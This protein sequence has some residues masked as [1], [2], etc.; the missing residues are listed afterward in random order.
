[1]VGLGKGKVWA[2]S[3][4]AVFSLVLLTGMMLPAMNVSAQNT[5]EMDSA[6]RVA[7]NKK[8]LSEAR[9][10]WLQKTDEAEKITQYE[11]Q[12]KD[13]VSEADR[14]ALDA[15]IQE[16]LA[17]IE[18]LSAQ[19]Q[20]LEELNKKLYVMDPDLRS[21]L[22]AASNL[23]YNK[24]VNQSSTSYIGEN[25]VEDVSPLLLTRT[26]EILVNPEKLAVDKSNLPEETEVDGFPVT[27]EYGTLQ[28]TSCVSGRQS[29]CRP[30][31][32]GIS[33]ADQSLA[34]D[35]NTMGYKAV[36]NGYVGFVIAGHTSTGVLAN[37]VQ[38]H[39]D[40]TKT[41]GVVVV[42]DPNVLDAAFVK[43]NPGITV[44]DDICAGTTSCSTYYDAVSK[45]PDSQQTEGTFIIKA[46]ASGGSDL[47]EVSVNYP[48]RNNIK[49]YVC[50]WA[51]GDSGSTIF[52]ESG[53][54][55]ADI[56]GMMHLASPTTCYVYYYPQDII[57]SKIGANPAL[58]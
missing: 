48:D 43:A 21:R 25:P 29:E 52:H 46:G 30:L 31:V 15:K 22:F 49:A 47:G 10:A 51:G 12:K 9:E 58:S 40:S 33:V 11:D 13:A 14:L 19:I 28:E 42:D 50:G 26:L 24:Y 18:Q 54:S 55:G 1:M 45:R 20:A 4:A 36:R 32:A 39:N 53:G 16:S 3:A 41:V 5:E 44:T 17:K 35:L 8:Y 38:P 27:I 34:P 56:F 2:I 23:L 7:L 57:Y 6:T 37:I